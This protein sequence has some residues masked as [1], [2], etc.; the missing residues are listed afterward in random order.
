MTYRIQGLSHEPFS[1]LFG[2]NDEELAALRAR[3]VRAAG[4]GYPCR[5]SLEDAGEGEELLL[6]NYVSHDVDTPFRTA[7]AIYV[8]ETAAEAP[9]YCNEVP[10]LID[11]RTVS[12]RGFD[13]AGMLRAGLLAMPG[14]ADRSIRELFADPEVAII[15]A[16]NAALG[17]FLA[18]VERD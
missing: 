12:L 11:R 3:R 10:G 1:H 18:K 4:G 7:H 15:H 9:V 14:E 13:V 2:L 5:V 16:H 8:R 6:L 17:C